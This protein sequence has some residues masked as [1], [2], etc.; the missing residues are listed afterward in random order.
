MDIFQTPYQN[1]KTL[2]MRAAARARTRAEWRRDT[3]SALSRECREID[4]D[5]SQVN[6][7]LTDIEKGIVRTVLMGGWMDEFM[8]AKFNEDI[9][10]TC[11]YC[12]EDE[13]TADHI[14]WKCKFFQ[15][16]RIELDKQLAEVPLQYLPLS[17]RSGI[18]P[19]MRTDGQCTYWGREIGND[20][21]QATKKILGIDLELHTPGK[22]A[23]VTS[24]RQEALQIINGPDAKGLNARQVILKCKR[25][26]GTGVDLEFPSQQQID[27][28]MQGVDQNHFVAIYGDGSQTSPTNWRAGLGGF[29]VWVPGWNNAGE[30]G[31]VT[32][33]CGVGRLTRV[34]L[35]VGRWWRG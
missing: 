22:D 4:S 34:H 27:D 5:I 3:G 17:I 25:G 9:D 13:A 21:D 18:A 35:S 1:L 28:H 23:K 29:G 10:K 20:V 19:A 15:P 24:A 30:D 7:K 31:V 6:P 33:G 26:H 8:M 32:D 11:N 14:K 12:K 2:T 16:K